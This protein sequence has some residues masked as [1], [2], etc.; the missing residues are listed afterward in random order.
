MKTIC[1]TDNFG[2]SRNYEIVETMPQGYVVW[3]IGENMGT[4][5]YIPICRRLRP[6]IKDD[7]SI[8]GTTLKAINL[9]KDDVIK[10]RKAASVGV[11]N[12]ETA[13]KAIMSNRQGYMSNRKKEIAKE[14]I[15][16]FTRITSN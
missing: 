4:S 13:K 1:T 7:Y 11:N 10:L 14:V 8:D 9:P 2:K 15:S 6:E 12:L 16:I 5:E 3:N